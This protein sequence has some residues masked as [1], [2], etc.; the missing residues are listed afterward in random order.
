MEYYKKLYI[1]KINN[2]EKEFPS[3]FFSGN[4]LQNHSLETPKIF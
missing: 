1:P 2:R 4:S 3:L